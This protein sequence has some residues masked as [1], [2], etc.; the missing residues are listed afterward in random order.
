MLEAD[1]KA[2][3][4]EISHTALMER[5]RARIKDKRIC[6]LVKAFLKSGVMTEPEIGKR[7]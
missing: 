7:H 1:I 4:D 3:F 5:F 6:A 2:C